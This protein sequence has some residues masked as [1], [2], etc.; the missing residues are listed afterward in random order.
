MTLLNFIGNS[1]GG[2][3]FVCLVGCSMHKVLELSYKTNYY[4]ENINNNINK[5]INKNNDVENSYEE[6]CK[7]CFI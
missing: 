6:F 2:T 3:F 4:I 5:N 7:S 1:F